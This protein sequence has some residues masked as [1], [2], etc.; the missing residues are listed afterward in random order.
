MSAR[1]LLEVALRILGLW[2][3]ASTIS[4]VTFMASWYVADGGATGGVGLNYLV[5]TGAYAVVQSA[6]GIALIR[7]APNISARFYPSDVQESEPQIHVG[8]GDIYH[9]AC[10][11]LGVY[12]LVLGVDFS[13][14]LAIEGL[15]TGWGNQLASAAVSAIVYTA[16]SLLL[17]FGSRRIGQLV[18][19]L[20]YDPD[21]IPQQQFSL[22][23]LLIITVLVAVILGVIRLISVPG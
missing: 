22:R 13:G 6:L 1:L 5:S 20:Q 2:L 8:P 15:S 21:S 7:W 10:F 16:S 18:S 14:K 4:T 23:L 19:N 12:L 17:I 3:L 9:T 11:V